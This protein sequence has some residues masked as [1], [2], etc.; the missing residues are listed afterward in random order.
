MGNENIHQHRENF[1]ILIFRRPK[2]DITIADSL[3][4]AFQCAVCD[5]YLSK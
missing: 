4:R 2:I 5:D 1:L 3:G